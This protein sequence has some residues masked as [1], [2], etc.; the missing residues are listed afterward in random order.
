MRRI[1]FGCGLL[2]L[3]STARFGFAEPQSSSGGDVFAGQDPLSVGKVVMPQTSLGTCTPPGNSNWRLVAHQGETCYY[4]SPL[5][6]RING[7]VTSINNVGAVEKAGGRCG[8]DEF[9]ASMAVCQN[10]EDTFAG[11]SPTKGFPPS[12]G[13]GGQPDGSTASTGNYR[14]QPAPPAYDP[15]HPNYN[16][17]T[18]AGRAAAQQNAGQDQQACNDERCKHN[19][20]L[21]F[22]GGPTTTVQV[23]PPG[24]KDLDFRKTGAP[25]PVMVIPAGMPDLNVVVNKMND[26]LKAKVPYWEPMKI[27]SDYMDKARQS[28]SEAVRSAQPQTLK[29]QTQVFL[30]ETA[31][32]MQAQALH[33]QKFGAAKPSSP[34]IKHDTYDPSDRRDYSNPAYA[35]AYVAGWLQRCLATNGMQSDDDMRRPYASFLGVDVTDG[36]IYAFGAGYIYGDVLAP[37]TM[38]PTTPAH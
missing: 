28:A 1:I 33:D 9:D 27:Q 25:P 24:Q 21:P 15:C 36:R 22:C 19:P 18:A 6:K 29:Y 7:Y 17:S 8:V 16:M 11:A 26:C 3:M 2:I 38:L 35:P 30:V 34:A 32:G 12:T 23:P 13:G 5:P 37:A 31:M 4:V 14:R 10:A 20:G